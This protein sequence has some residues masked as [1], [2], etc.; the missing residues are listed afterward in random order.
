MDKQKNYMQDDLARTKMMRNFDAHEKRM[1]YRVNADYRLAEQP[2]T[3]RLLVREMHG[4]LTKA[5][6]KQLADL[7]ANL[8]EI[9]MMCDG[10]VL[11]EGRDV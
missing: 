5:E 4:M 2:A 6:V 1:V 9:N 3:A 11:T 7:R 10:L 8:I